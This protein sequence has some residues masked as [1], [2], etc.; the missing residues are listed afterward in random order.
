MPYSKN[1]SRVPTQISILLFDRFSNHCLANVLEPLRAA[2][3]LSSQQV[4]EWNIVVLGGQ[5][6][7]SSSGLRLE[8]DAQLA[9]MRGDILMVMPSYGFLTHANVTSSR[10]LRAAARRFDTLAGLDTGSWLLAEAGLLD[11]YRA[12]I[13][14]DELDRFSERFSDIDVQKEAVIYDRDRITC[15]GASTAFALAMQM[16]EKQHGA[17]LRLR[18]E[19]LFS[20]AYAQR[21]VRRG[22]IAARAVDLMRAHIEE[23]LPIAQ[24]AQQ[25]G[26]SQKHLEQQMLARLGAAPQVI[27]RRIRLERARQLSLDTTISV[28]EISLR[29]GYQDASAMT[30][31]FRSE[32]GT[33]PQALRRAST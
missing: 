24:L 2:N 17:A 13:H 18:V 22:G 5:R 10:A 23:P 28:A 27:Y 19:H 6:V 14:W 32:Y 30:R 4:F 26:R 3:D 20:G 7:R 9:D 16:I 29:C 8:A 33:T 25:L 12:T 11:G 31:A 15:G 21:P 1:P